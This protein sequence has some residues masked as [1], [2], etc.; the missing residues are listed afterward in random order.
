MYGDG[1]IPVLYIEVM[2]AFEPPDKVGPAIVVPLWR[3]NVQPLGTSVIVIDGFVVGEFV[4]AGIVV[5][6]VDSMPVV[7]SWVAGIALPMPL[8]VN[9]VGIVNV[10]V[11]GGAWLSLL[12]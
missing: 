5:V 9:G 11:L 12:S 4:V 7:P 6:I 10:E 3:Q 1:S 8:L 2:A